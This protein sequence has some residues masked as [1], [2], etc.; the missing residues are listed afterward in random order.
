MK[1]SKIGMTAAILLGLCFLLAIISPVLANMGYTETSAFLLNILFNFLIPATSILLIWAFIDNLRIAQ[2]TKIKNKDEIGAKQK[3]LG[4][5]GLL[6]ISVIIL[7]I[8]SF[9]YDNDF[10]LMIL[11]FIL[12]AISFVMGKRFGQIII[13]K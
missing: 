9:F 4:I 11:M 6:F 12:F 1:Y 10:Y 5:F 7:M 13:K 2:T 8:V 3:I